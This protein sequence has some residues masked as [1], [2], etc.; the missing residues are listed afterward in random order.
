MG[1]GPLL[2]GLLGN[3]VCPSLECTRIWLICAQMFILFIFTTV[4]YT[5]ISILTLLSCLSVS[6]FACLG[7]FLRA[8]S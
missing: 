1:R 5:G 2:P 4:T 3:E 7:F 6:L 8:N